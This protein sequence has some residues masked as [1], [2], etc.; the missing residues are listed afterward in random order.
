MYPAGWFADPRD[1]NMLRY[2]DGQAWTEHQRP[3][4]PAAAAPVAPP[5]PAEPARPIWAPEPTAP[6][7]AEPAQ[8]PQHAWQPEPTAALP[9]TPAQPMQPPQHTQ[10]IWEAEPTAALPVVPAQPTWG[11]PAAQ[12]WQ[13]AP[14]PAWQQPPNV[15]GYP[16][17]YPPP[18]GGRRN[19]PL[20]IGLVAVLVAGLLTGG[21]FVFFGGDN[22]PKLTYQ[23]AKIK[24]ASGV[25]KSAEQSLDSVVTN[26]HGAKGDNTRCYYA[27]LKTQPSGAK[28]TDVD[29]N[30]RCGPVLFVDGDPAN[31]YLKFALTRSGT[32]TPATLTAA[33]SPLTDV[34]VAADDVKLQR[35][36][37]KKAPSGAGGL[38]APAPPAAA[39]DS[40][41]A[42][43][44]GSTTVPAAPK[45]AV[46][47]S[48][49]GG[50]A[51]TNLG[52][53]TRYGKDDEARSAPSGQKLIAF[54]ATG[55]PGNDLVSTDLT[56][57]A[58]VSVDGGTA[59]DVPHA[60]SGQYV[61]VAVSTGARS[62]DLVLDDKGLK[63]SISLL[64]GKPGTGNVVVLA[65]KNRD[66][67][68]ATTTKAVFTF[69][70]SVVFA[71]NTSGT[72]ENATVTFRL[73]DISYRNTDQSKSVTASS[74]SKAIMHVAMTYVGAHDKGTFGFPAGLLTFTPTG[75]APVHARNISPVAGR[76]FNVFEVPGN[77]TTGAL[78]LSGSVLQTFQGSAGSYRFGIRTPVKIPIAIPAG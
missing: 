16:P 49:S 37:G 10:P 59:R 5:Q 12:A 44:L 65:R 23:G 25:L 2:Y 9:V 15:G 32:D 57:S 52:P 60:S 17:Q 41:A 64:D 38:K 46:I 29:T 75:G 11:E 19:R 72:S 4:A 66:T 39:A 68:R 26:R 7:R 33:T 13:P 18:A 63:Q 55:A 36:D 47:G 43:D 14:A 51:L 6:Q 69:A 20:I 28:K 24:D 48:W 45:G 71:D 70:P 77:V 73:A 76:I 31:E 62:V 21:Y 34:P 78:T 30:L 35:P 40:I 56:S 1:P 74:H 42:A 8:P 61:V 22:A 58:T 53:V 50:I 54:A 67:A 3:V 27:V